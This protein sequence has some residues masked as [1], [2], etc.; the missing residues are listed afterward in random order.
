MLPKCIKF[1]TLFEYF[2][3]DQQLEPVKFQPQN[4]AKTLRLRCSSHRK[5]PRR[6]R[7]G[8]GL[9]EKQIPQD[10]SPG[11]GRIT[12]HLARR[13]ALVH[14]TA[15][16]A[17]AARGRR[18]HRRRRCAQ[19]LDLW[20]LGQRRQRL[21]LLLVQFLQLLFQTDVL[22]DVVRTGGAIDR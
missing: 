18:R 13:Y 10:V 12:S 11:L 7:G 19:L 3:N 16:A 9:C 8:S 2:S 14:T 6:S 20:R 4:Q 17:A 21:L 15:A 1:T 22:R 5:F